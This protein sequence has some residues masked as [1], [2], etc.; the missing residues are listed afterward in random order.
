MIS[1]TEL[2]GLRLP[3]YYDGDDEYGSC[4]LA[5]AEMGMTWSHPA[6]LTAGI[7]PECWC[8]ASDHNDKLDAI[9]Q[10]LEEAGVL[11]D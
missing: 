2:E 7:K 5:F 1:R 3:H 8:N 9:I 10:Q 11:E 4:P 6:L